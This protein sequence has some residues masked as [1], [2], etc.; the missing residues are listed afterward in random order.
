MWRNDKMIWS[1]ILRETT[2]STDWDKDTNLCF[3]LFWRSVSWSSN[4]INAALK[5]QS[6]LPLSEERHSLA[7]R[8]AAP[9]VQWLL[10]CALSYPPP[11][12]RVWIQRG[13]EADRLP[14]RQLLL[15][16]SPLGPVHLF[17]WVKSE[18]WAS[19]VKKKKKRVIVFCTH[20]VCLSTE[21]TNALYNQINSKKKIF[22]FLLWGC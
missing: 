2:D 7:W 21:V 6:S 20:N 5:G 22:F 13:Q 17:L 1:Q 3:C 4:A 15:L 12:L 14:T 18:E 19:I 8:S 16:Y 10:T 9:R 11:G